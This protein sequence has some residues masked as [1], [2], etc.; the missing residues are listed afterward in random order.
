LNRY[1]VRFRSFSAGRIAASNFGQ[2]ARHLAAHEFWKLAAVAVFEPPASQ[3][4]IRFEIVDR[5]RIA[6][7]IIKLDVACDLLDEF[8]RNRD[9][10]V[11][12]RFLR[13]HFSS[14]AFDL[15]DERAALAGFEVVEPDVQ[16]L[17]RHLHDELAFAAI[18]AYARAEREKAAARNGDD[19]RHF[20]VEARERVDLVH[21]RVGRN[22]AVRAAERRA[23]EWAWRT[24]EKGFAAA[25][26]FSAR[27]SNR[28][29]YAF[30]ETGRRYCGA[31]DL[32]I[33]LV[34][35]FGLHVVAILLGKAIA[36]HPVEI[37]RASPAASGAKCS[38]ARSTEVSTRSQINHLRAKV[39]I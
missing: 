7:L 1:A 13:H 39:I 23:P 35:E 30:R 29:A 38:N 4:L 19:L 12:P 32:A 31:L 3:K 8:A 11:R 36:R 16:L 28:S 2:Y 33:F 27:A 37:V 26:Q 25:A 14:K 24:V 9:A 15:A 22:G 6:P 20:A 5:A 17:A 10:D 34:V 18:A 21:V